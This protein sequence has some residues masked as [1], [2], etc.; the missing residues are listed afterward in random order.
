[1]ETAKKKAVGGNRCIAAGCSNTNRAGVS[2]FRF[3]KDDSQALLWNREV[4]RTRLD[5][6]THTKYSMLCSDHFEKS[7]FE[8]GPL[9]RAQM[10]IATPRRLVLKKGAG[11]TIFNIPRPG[12]SGSVTVSAP[13]ASASTSSDHHTPSTSGQTVP[14]WS[15]SNKRR[16]KV[17]IDQIMASTTTASVVDEPMATALDLP[18]EEGDQDQGSK[19]GCQRD[20]VPIGTAPTPMTSSRSTRTGKRHHRSKGQQVT[21][22]ILERVRAR[23]ARVSEVPSSSV[24]APSDSPEMQPNIATPDIHQLIGH[25]E[26]CLPPLQGGGFTVEHGYPQPPRVKEEEDPQPLDI[27]E[28]KEDTQNPQDIHQLIG[29]QEG[30]LPP[31]QGGD[32]TVEHGYP[33]QPRVKEEEDPQPLD[34]KE[35][36]EDTQHPQDVQ[37]PPHIKEEEEEFWITQEEDCLLGQEEADLTKF[38]LTVVL[39][40]T[41]DHEEKPPECSQLHHSPNVCEEGLLPEQQ[42]WT[43]RMNQEEP[44]PPHIKEEEVEPQ[45]P[46]I[47]EEEVELQDPH[48]KDEEEE[49]SI[50]REEKHIEE[51]EKVVSKKPLTGVTVKSEEEFKE[52]TTTRHRAT[53]FDPEWLK[54]PQ[55]KSWLYNTQHGMFCRLCRQHKPAARK[56]GK[57]AFVEFGGGVYR[58]DYIERHIT[59]EHHQESVRC[60]ASFAS[61]MSLVNAFEPPVVVEHEAVIGGFKCLY[62]LIKNG[63]AH[64]TNYPKLLSLAELLGC[65]YFR[66]LKLDQR[67]NYR[68]HRIIDEMLEIL[69]EVIEEPVLSEIQS[70]KAITLEVDESTSVST[71]KQFDVHVRYLDKE[72]RVF[73]QFLD[74]VELADGKAHTIVAAIKTAICKK[75]LPTER[76][77]GLGTD[78]AAV[79]TGR[80]NGVVKQLTDSYPK[81]LGVACAAH[82]LALA[83]KDSSIHVKYM[84]TFRDHLQDLYLLFRNSANRTATLKAASI[85][86]GVSDLKIKEVKDTCWLSEHKAIENLQRNLPAV[87]AALAEEAEMRRCPVAKGLYTFCATYRFVAAVYLQADV[88]PHL[89]SLSRVFQKVDV[90]FLHIKE[91]VPVTI[92]TLRNIR[93]AGQTPLPGSF[94]SRL[95]KDLDN[96]QGLGAFNIEHEE[97][98]DRR[99]RRQGDGQEATREGQWARFQQEVIHPYLSGLEKNLHLRFHDLDIL[100]A[101]SVFGPKSAALQDDSANIDNLR[102]LARKFCPEQQNEVLQEWTSFKNHVLTGAFKDKN[103]ADILTL[104]ASEFD[105][106]DNVYPCLS[107][108]AGENRPEESSARRTPGG[109]PENLHQRT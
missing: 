87:L 95:H 50:S 61:G 79:M 42:E 99:G 34:I 65:D 90:N 68:S 109:L 58:K 39:V 107:L 103:Q 44:Q 6:T 86:L 70:S 101:F 24:A 33:Q 26:R 8:E 16:R 88:L 32:F 108:L 97:E 2:L 91:M 5:W 7:C 83:C 10:G 53:G 71:T 100:G 81:M 49:H 55:L 36:N 104:L 78:G 15:V 29:H 37:Q 21:S 96:S 41:E 98:R 85:T 28:E 30:C 47:K 57:R 40:K 72:G 25:Q 56:E 12:I 38:P 18:D 67:N 92:S 31:L 23:P 80:V 20:W 13:S 17:T 27:K 9:L 75:G 89:A 54:M 1:M 73:N 74:L 46:Y 19:Q 11:P 102:I 62:W 63:L 45:D 48:I 59:T 64:H 77:Y 22:E 105:E 4:K 14:T 52:R 84:A 51:L 66:K 3:P 94:L 93:E 43:S 82:G 35:E 60:Q 76:L 69:G 106:W